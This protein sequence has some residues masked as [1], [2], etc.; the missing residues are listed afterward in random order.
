M[1]HVVTAPCFGCRFT[2]CL[3]VCPVECFH[4]GEKMLYIDPEC[5]T[6]CEACAMECPTEAIFPDH[7]VPAK[8]REFIALNADM[9]RKT[10]PIYERREPLASERGA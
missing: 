2:D 1:T 5:C 7:K 9:V 4:E 8:W 6:D 3:V 10:P